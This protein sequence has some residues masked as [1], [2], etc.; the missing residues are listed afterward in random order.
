VQK[1][2]GNARQHFRVIAR[3]AVQ[4]DSERTPTTADA[5]HYQGNPTGCRGLPA[6][7]LSTLSSSIARLEN[8]RGLLVPVELSEASTGQAPRLEDFL[9]DS[10]RP[11]TYAATAIEPARREAGSHG[12]LH[13][14]R[15]AHKRK[16][17][18]SRPRM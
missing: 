14:Q 1:R 6:D 16:A 12:K 5:S 10:A 9:S 11:V 13:A 4:N 15:Q 7:R 3:V 17:E 8:R 2:R 18:R